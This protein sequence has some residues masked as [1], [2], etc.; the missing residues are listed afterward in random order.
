MLVTEIIIVSVD[1]IYTQELYA[2]LLIQFKKC[3]DILTA[4]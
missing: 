3:N 1:K 4:N 2:D